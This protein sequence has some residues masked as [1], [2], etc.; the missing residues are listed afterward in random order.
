MADK[1]RPS[2]TGLTSGNAPLARHV[3]QKGEET[4]DK[5]AR[6]VATKAA[7][8]KLHRLIINRA[9]ELFVTSATIRFRKLKVIIVYTVDSV[10]PTQK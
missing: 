8:G 10:G 3:V 9:F 7:S 4:H 2:L 5:P 6:E 1:K